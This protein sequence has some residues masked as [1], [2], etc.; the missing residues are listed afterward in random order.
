MPHSVAQ[1]VVMCD[2]LF[3]LFVEDGVLEVVP[4]LPLLARAP[5]ELIPVLPEVLDYRSLVG[6]DSVSAWRG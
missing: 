1:L 4:D 2:R 6:V 3:K 5:R